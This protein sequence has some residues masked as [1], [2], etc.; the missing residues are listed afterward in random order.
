ME[1]ADLSE[2]E[3]DTALLPNET[4]YIASKE[5]TVIKL[6]VYYMNKYFMPMIIFIGLIGNSIAM[7]VFLGTYL[8][9]L[10]LSIYLAALSISDT[11]FLL[12]MFII[13]LE[14]VQVPLFHTVGIC[15]IVVYTSYTSGFLSVWFVVS[16]SVERFI[17]IWIPLRKPDMCTTKRAKMVVIG[18]S[19][20][21]MLAYSC[22]LRT[23]GLKVIVNNSRE[24]VLCTPLNEYNNIH[25]ILLFSDTVITMFIPFLA[26]LFLN[27]TIAY[28]I[29]FFSKERWSIEA[30]ETYLLRN[31]RPPVSIT[32]LCNVAQIKVT[33]ML[34][35]VSTVFL[36]VN[37]PSY[38][39]R[40]Q[41]FLTSFIEVN[42]TTPIRQYLF[43]HV[44][45]MIYYIGFSINFFLYSYCSDRF[46]KAMA[47]FFSQLRY[48]IS[49]FWEQ[50]H[51]LFRRAFNRPE[52]SSTG[53]NG[54]KR[55]LHRNRN[56][57]PEHGID[58]NRNIQDI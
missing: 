26:I 29:W 16:F 13:W 2:M 53:S 24:F 44:S 3:N 54:S 34:L 32:N 57:S 1:M 12:C 14:Y 22:S 20:F 11:I 46:R 56:T 51:V 30:T 47:R 18:L 19:V 40:I 10:S 21:A 50:R 25:Q 55:M 31:T 27:T 9:R 48:K 28:R 58:F 8:R 43:L 23:V 36:V 39:V 35:I 15:Q 6:V 4:M 17:A 5:E 38:I 52:S 33:K 37:L 41:V 7:I 49:N 42:Y 45:Q